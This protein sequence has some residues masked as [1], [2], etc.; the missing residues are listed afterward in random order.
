MT[1]PRTT[2]SAGRAVSAAE[3]DHSLTVLTRHALTVRTGAAPTS[4]T[5]A[6]GPVVLRVSWAGETT[7]DTSAG[8][9]GDTSDVGQLISSVALTAG[10]SHGAVGGPNGYPAN[11]ND[12][13]AIGNGG[14][15]TGTSGL[16]GAS[17]VLG[18]GQGA[19]GGGHGDSSF[20][21]GPAAATFTLTAETVGVFYRSSEPG[22]APFVAE[23]D[24]VRAGQQVG[25]VEAMK[26]MI[27]IQAGKEG[28]VAEFLVADG[29]A[30][31]H[32]QPLIVFEV[33]R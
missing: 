3:A 28:V 11:G 22:A 20:G 14:S 30:V 15:G 1:D 17:S 18:G 26:L 19:R 10:P 2:E 21:N 4:I 13:S 33:L 8:H 5:V 23:G 6:N 31:E 27:P 12:G 9:S 7:S 16:G 25:I 24:P 32:G 29:E